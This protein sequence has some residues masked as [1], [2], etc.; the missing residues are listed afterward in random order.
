[1]RQCARIHSFQ[2]S[3]AGS[4]ADETQKTTSFVC[5]Q[6]P[7]AGSRL[8]TVRSKR[9]T[10]LIS[11]S[12]GV[13]RNHAL[14]G[15]TVN[16][17]VSQRL[18]PLD[19]GRVRADRLS[20]GG[21]QFEPA[22][23]AR[24]VVL[25]LGEQMIARGDHALEGFFWACSAS[26]VNTQPFRPSASIS[27]GAAG[28]SLLFSSTI[29]WPSTIWSACRNADIMCAA[30]RSL[31]ASK[32]PRS[33]LPSTAIATRPSDEAAA[34]KSTTHAARNAASNAVGSTPW[35][36]SRNPRVGGRI[37]QPQAKRFVQ[38]LQMNANEFMHLPV[39]IGPGDHAENGVEQH[40]RQIEPLAFGATMVWDRAQNLQ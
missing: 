39:G 28:I 1:M 17:R 36:I 7:V 38:A 22:A 16:S 40:G 19:L 25:D 13:W 23:Q 32:L 4:E 15:N 30:L 2:R 8:Q 33:V 29:R 37:G 34:S 3:G 31:K 35:M 18:R 24:L 21:S 6:S 20:P 12:H 10:V 14:A 9:S 26:S 27:S 11:F 5:A